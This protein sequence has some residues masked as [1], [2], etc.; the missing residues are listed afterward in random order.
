MDKHE[1]SVTAQIVAFVVLLV[2][3]WQALI[4]ALAVAAW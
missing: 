1:L 4:D 3:D 2:S